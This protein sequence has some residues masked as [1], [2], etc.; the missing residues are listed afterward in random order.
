MVE[1]ISISTAARV[2]NRAK[3]QAL[4][5]VSP[6]K[7]LAEMQHHRRLERHRPALPTIPVH[8]SDVVEALR[9][10]AIETMAIDDLGIPGT[11]ELKDVLGQQVSALAARPVRGATTIEPSTT[12][13]FE[14]PALWRWGL[15]EPMLDLAEN[16]LGM[17][18]RY[19]GAYVRR[20]VADGQALDV[21][22]WH[23]DIEDRTSLKILI[24]L[25]DVDEDGGPF[26][27]LPV[28]K[29]DHAVETLRYVAGFVTDEEMRRV[30]PESEWR[31]CPG[32]RWTAVLADNCRLLH[33]ATPP[34][35]KDRYSV[36]FTWTTRH[37][38][39]TMPQ[40]AMSADQV[41]RLTTGLTWR[42]FE[43]LPIALQRQAR[44]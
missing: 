39:K 31:T 35:A 4:A 1:S 29:S 40:E 17:P 6:V 43:C 10:N 15:S 41:R 30:V 11:S 36:T 9:A 7:R 5:R 18:A 3:R 8:H 22:Q 37:P 2:V 13:L 23:R 28:E 38:V 19:Y 27:Y 16:Y 33:R 20:E 14:D 26:A 21:R 25:N 24:W 34:Q 12:E 44:G 42:Q 32:P